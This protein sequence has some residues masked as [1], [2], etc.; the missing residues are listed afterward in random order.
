MGEAD[1]FLKCYHFFKSFFR[2]SFFAIIENIFICQRNDRR[3]SFVGD[4][5][6]LD[7]TE[8]SQV[9]NLNLNSVSY[10]IFD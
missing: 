8:T 4:N 6:L 10:K 2:A 3:L 9:A 7:E 1:F 5:N